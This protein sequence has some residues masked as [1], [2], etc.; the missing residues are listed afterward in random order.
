ME[1]GPSRETESH[2]ANQE[3]S[4]LLRNPKVQYYVH[5]SPPLV[6]ILN[7][8]YPVH[9]FPHYFSKIYYNIIFPSMTMFSE[10]S[11]PFRF[12]DENTACISHLTHAGYMCHQS[13]P[14]FHHPNNV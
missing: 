7:K 2:V 14:R 12:L 3:I 11:P 8:M 4:H 1:Q 9:N 5:R 13:Y 6:P 10:W